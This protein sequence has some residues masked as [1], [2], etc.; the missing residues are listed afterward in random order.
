MS[1][2][3]DIDKIFEDARDRTLAIGLYLERFP[4]DENDEHLK[5][6]LNSDGDDDRIIYSAISKVS[7]LLSQGE[8]SP[9]GV[10]GRKFEFLIRLLYSFYFD[11][12]LEFMNW[13]E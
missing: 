11:Y 13:S 10:L 2:Y 12:E 8:R 4:E 9:S 6:I 1:D 3:K 7:L 5:D